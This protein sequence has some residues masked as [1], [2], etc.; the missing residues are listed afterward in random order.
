MKILI[1][2]GNGMIGHKLYQILSKV[3]VET[4]VV[5]RRD[6]N[7][8]TYK[9]MFN[10][11]NTFSKFD[12]YEI[13]KLE[14]F[15]NDF[16]PDIIINAAGI[17]IRRGVDTD[18]N[19]TLVLNSILPKYLSLWCD[20]NKKWLIHL[21]T[22][23]VFSGSVGDYNEKD[24]PDARNIYGISKSLGEVAGKNSLVLRSSYI[25][26]ELENNTELLEWFLR[27]NE[28]KV[29]G[30][31]N[32]IYSGISTLKLAEYILILIND[33]YRLCGLYNISS[34]PISKYELLKH[35]K[36]KFKK[37][38]DI[39][40]STDHYSNKSLNSEMFFNLLKLPS[41]NWGSMSEEIF[42]DSVLN[43]S[44]YNK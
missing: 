17:T 35:F 7:N 44:L 8:L 42:L 39:I 37:N 19:K 30:Y 6:Y 9:K 4:Y 1:L 11:K 21:S 29:V 32:V 15:L 3:Y 22:D 28:T 12:L 41:P 14:I 43:E 40:E 13:D 10:Q 23:C 34:Q 18:I 27:T 38:I 5:L 36:N 25:G 26:R 33:H 31:K 20:L 2:G 16:Q 24:F